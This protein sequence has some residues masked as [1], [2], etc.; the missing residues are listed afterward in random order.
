MYEKKE[1]PAE[2][3]AC[4]FGCRMTADNSLPVINA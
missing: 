4:S 3:G 2:V 1:A